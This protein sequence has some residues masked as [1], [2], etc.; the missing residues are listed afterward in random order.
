M[1]ITATEVLEESLPDMR[2]ES[3]PGVPMPVTAPPERLTPRRL[4][5]GLVAVSLVLVGVGVGLLAARSGDDSEGAAAST[6]EQ[7][8]VAEQRKVLDA[9]SPARADPKPPPGTEIATQPKPEPATQPKPKPVSTPEPEPVSAPEPKPTVQPKPAPEPKPIKKQAAKV[10]V[11]F[12]IV[13]ATSAR[14]E[15]GP[16]S[17]QYN[18]IAMLE[19]RPG[20]YKVRWR[21]SDTQPWHA[22]GT[23]RVAALAEGAYYEVR[24]GLSSVQVGQREEGS[25]K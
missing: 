3:V 25:A 16:H 8:V 17:I 22:A 19:L 21:E 23:V 13:G 14:L 9:K 11:T 18:Q 5:T 7:V 24:V 15:V 10:V 1:P 12:V 2:D 6:P 4:I 20:R